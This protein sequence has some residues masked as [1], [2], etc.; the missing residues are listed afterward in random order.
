LLS[1]S[2]LYSEGGM[3]QTA[4]ESPV[5]VKFLLSPDHERKKEA[6]VANPQLDK[7]NGIAVQAHLEDKELST[8]S[9]SNTILAATS[10]QSTHSDGQSATDKTLS[11]TLSDGDTNSIDDYVFTGGL[12]CPPD[13]ISYIH[14][15]LFTG[16]LEPI[17]D[18]LRDIPEDEIREQQSS[19][20]EKLKTPPAA[21]Q[22]IHHLQIELTAVASGPALALLA[23]PASSKPG[24]ESSI[25]FI[26]APQ[27]SALDA[28][29][30]INTD[31]QG[32][33]LVPATY[34]A[35]IRTSDEQSIVPIKHTSG[36]EG[37]CGVADASKGKADSTEDLAASGFQ[38]KKIPRAG[39]SNYSL[40]FSLQWLMYIYAPSPLSLPVFFRQIQ[41]A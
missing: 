27:Q 34:E 7:G 31:S 38:R 36:D 30:I 1:L 24:E 3:G 23:E 19:H 11:L 40:P 17:E 20:N 32:A 18:L 33:Y 25:K 6:L 2:L 21:L 41:R 4:V 13:D 35:T 16:A 26:H 39:N 37:T 12:A 10:S 22:V 29:E 8:T 15:Y 5:G 14:D 28:S 9:P